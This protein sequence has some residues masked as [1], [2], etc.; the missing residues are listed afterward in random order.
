MNEK[1]RTLTYGI[2]AIPIAFLGLP[3]YIYLPNF[4]VNEIGLNVAIVGVVLFLSRLVDMFADPFIGRLND[5]Y[6][7]SKSMILIGS[8]VLLISFYFLVHPSIFSYIW[9]FFFSTMTYIAFSFINISYLALNAK[10]GKNYNDNTK[11]SFSRE[12]F[13]IVGVLFALLIPHLFEVADD[14]QQSLSLMYNSIFI[15]LP[16]IVI[17]FL[18][19][20]KEQ[21]NEYVSSSMK[22]SLKKFLKDFGK[23]KSLFVAF[24]LNNLANA[25]PATLFLFFVD[26]VLKRPDSTGVL[27]LIYFLAAI[28]A[29]P[30]WIFLS[31]RFRKIKTF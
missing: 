24:I 5:V 19:F 26:L 31:K 12:I 3:L 18:V 30:L 10:L 4:Y 25:I 17:V 11:L 29:L 8:I 15:T 21:K 20:I 14:A 27:L 1:S 9:L 23:S 16:L 6:F 7:K 28:L 13:T 22:T 2:L